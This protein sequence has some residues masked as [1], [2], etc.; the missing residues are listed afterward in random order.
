MT[1][2]LARL[3]RW[4]VGEEGLFQ[5]TSFTP[6]ETSLV[7]THPVFVVFEQP[8]EI[9]SQDE[10]NVWFYFSLGLGPGLGLGLGLC[11]SHVLRSG[12]GLGL[13][14]G[15]GLGLGDQDETYQ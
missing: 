9:I 13:S 2:L 11:L 8:T 3:F 6:E 12:L 4:G 10:H 7:T 14:L 1:P 15:L 5:P